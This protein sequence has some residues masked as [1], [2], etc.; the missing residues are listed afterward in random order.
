MDIDDETEPI[1]LQ[2]DHF[3]GDQLTCA[4][5]RSSQKIRENSPT[6]SA[7]RL[8]GLIPVI[9]R[10]LTCWSVLNASTSIDN[11]IVIVGI[12]IVMHMHACR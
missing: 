1:T 11:S 6:G 3:R 4:H 10:G 7:A 9:Y 5:I 8:E 12:I 2:V